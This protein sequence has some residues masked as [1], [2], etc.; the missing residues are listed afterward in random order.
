MRYRVYFIFFRRYSPIETKFTRL[1]FHNIYD[2]MCT[3]LNGAMNQLEGNR[4]YTTF[5]I[6][7]QFGGFKVF[8]VMFMKNHQL[9]L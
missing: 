9:F 2:H 4:G 6:Q 7:Q 3:L 1:K 8:A 5:F